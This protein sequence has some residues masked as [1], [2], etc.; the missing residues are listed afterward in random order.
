[1]RELTQIITSLQEINQQVIDK[2][3]TINR[4]QGV[5]ALIS[6]M[7]NDSSFTHSDIYLDLRIKY[8]QPIEE[9]LKH[10]EQNPVIIEPENLFIPKKEKSHERFFTKEEVTAPMQINIYDAPKNRKTYVRKKRTENK[11]KKD[12]NA[13]SDPT[14]THDNQ[15]TFLSFH[16]DDNEYYLSTLTYEIYDSDWNFSGRLKDDKITLIINP[17][18]LET[19]TIT[20]KTQQE[21]TEPRLFGSYILE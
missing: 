21:S 5:I 19:E 1:M 9:H 4:M 13:S 18:T 14:D 6:Q 17:Q 12:P 20:L 10:L 2:D 3:N 15:G 7:V 8:I 16:H 11:E